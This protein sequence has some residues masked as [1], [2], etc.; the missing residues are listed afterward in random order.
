MEDVLDAAERE[1]GNIIALPRQGASHRTAALEQAAQAAE[2]AGAEHRPEAGRGAAD[3]PSRSGQA[4][5]MDAMKRLY[6]MDDQPE[7]ENRT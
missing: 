2:A 6:P 7:K 3:G 4:A 5:L 1:A